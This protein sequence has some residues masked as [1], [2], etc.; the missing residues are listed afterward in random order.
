MAT[1]SSTIQVS[2]LRKQT[3]EA[4]TTQAKSQGLSVAG[5]VKE[6]IETE[7][8]ITEMAR[9]KTFDEVLAPVRKQFHDSGMSDGELTRLIETARDEHRK[10][11]SK[12]K[13]R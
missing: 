1:A 8:S 9:T 10:E 3:L 12:K 13:K 4:L 5:F 2:G 6:L 11:V 7:M